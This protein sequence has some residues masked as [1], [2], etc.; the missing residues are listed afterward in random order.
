ME[1]GVS[2]LTR[3]RM[4]NALAMLIAQAA[5]AR[6]DVDEVEAAHKTAERLVRMPRYDAPHQGAREMERRRKQRTR[7]GLPVV[8]P[9]PVDPAACIGVDEESAS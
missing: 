1:E 4:V 6:G 7:A 9:A 3:V 2:G 5:A 8:E